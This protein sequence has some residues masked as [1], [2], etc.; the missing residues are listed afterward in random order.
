MEADKVIVFRDA[1]GEWRWKRVAANGEIVADS[2]EGYVHRQDCEDGAAR[3]GVE[4]V[5]EG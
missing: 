3:Q 2:G 5:S 1:S 4:V